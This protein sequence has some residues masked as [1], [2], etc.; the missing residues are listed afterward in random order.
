MKK[1]TARLEFFFFSN[2]CT[3]FKKKK[4]NVNDILKKD[5]TRGLLSR[6][7]KEFLQVNKKKINDT[8]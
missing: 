8:I 5:I 3:T 1:V 7:Y 4:T 6:T 2:I